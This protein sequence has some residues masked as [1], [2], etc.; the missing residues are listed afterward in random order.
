MKTF[1][2][3]LI[4]SFLSVSFAEAQDTFNNHPVKVTTWRGKVLKYIDRELAIKLKPGIQFD[5][6]NQI[7][8]QHNA[9]V[10]KSPDQLGWFWIELPEGSD[11]FSVIDG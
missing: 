2:N 1:I 11:I 3:I 8:S 5:Q 4:I 6:I 10:M 7:L 9:V